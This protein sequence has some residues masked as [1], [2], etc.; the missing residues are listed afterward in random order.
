V[1]KLEELMDKQE[2]E[3]QATMRAF[4]KAQEAAEEK[5]QRADRLWVRKEFNRLF[6]RLRTL[7]DG[8]WDRY[9][10]GWKFQ[11]KGHDYWIAYEHWFSPKTSG[12]ADDYDMEGNDWVLKPHF[13]ALR[14]DYIT[15]RHLLPREEDEPKEYTE[16]VLDGLRDLKKRGKFGV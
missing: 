9:G 5:R 8:H 16:A 12:D 15:L 13:N 4:A 10:W 14:G 2:R 1:S 7:V 6:K 11:Y 3:S